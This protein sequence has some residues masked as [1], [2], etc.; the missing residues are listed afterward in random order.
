MT[1]VPRVVFCCWSLGVLLQKEDSHQAMAKSAE[2]ERVKIS[3]FGLGS[4]DGDF[5]KLN[6]G[7]GMFVGV[8]QGFWH[9]IDAPIL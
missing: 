6:A 5:G 3:E 1:A 8:I 7:Y 2:M 9:A 4:S